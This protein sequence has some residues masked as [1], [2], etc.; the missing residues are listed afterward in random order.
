MESGYAGVVLSVSSRLPCLS[1]GVLFEPFLS[2]LWLLFGPLF[3]FA[4]CKEGRAEDGVVPRDVG[5]V[6]TRV[7]VGVL[8]VC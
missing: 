4:G 1:F 6:L 5:V 3:K 8:G 2:L 7:D